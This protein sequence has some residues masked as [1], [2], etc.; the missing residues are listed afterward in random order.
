M[1]RLQVDRRRT[2]LAPVSCPARTQ[3]DAAGRRRATRTGTRPRVHNPLPV[4]DV[5]RHCWQR[6]HARDGRRPV[7]NGGPILPQYGR[8]HDSLSGCSK[9]T[10]ATFVI[11]FIV[12][13]HAASC[14]VWHE[15][16]RGRCFS[17][18]PAMMSSPQ[19][20]I[21]LIRNSLLPPDRIRQLWTQDK[22]CATCT[23]NWIH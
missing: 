23:T 9:Q 2:A 7:A 1:I 5:S 15:S 8:L 13:S 12:R 22:Y 11:T 16:I 17:L 4:P 10:T 18:L 3:A 20:S 14:L 21:R 6:S 19:Q